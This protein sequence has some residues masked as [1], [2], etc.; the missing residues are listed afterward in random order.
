[1]SLA[2][3]HSPEIGVFFKISKIPEFCRNG[4]VAHID[5]VPFRFSLLNRLVVLKPVHIRIPWLLVPSTRWGTSLFVRQSRIVVWRHYSPPFQLLSNVDGKPTVNVPDRAV[6]KL[7]ISFS[8]SAS[9]P[10]FVMAYVML[11][12]SYCLT[13][14][15]LQ[16]IARNSTRLR[17]LRP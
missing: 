3:S 15:E 16:R 2:S 1:M 17:S 11:L 8:L 9:S 5:C 6:K 14:M 10:L 12:L 13:V 4:K 7:A